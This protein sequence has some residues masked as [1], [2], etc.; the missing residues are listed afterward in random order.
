[1]NV[2]DIILHFFIF[3]VLNSMDP[4]T[5]SVLYVG[6]M[7]VLAFVFNRIGSPRSF[8]SSGSSQS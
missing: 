3:M 6:S 4:A 8:K 2:Q 1:M 5:F 7:C